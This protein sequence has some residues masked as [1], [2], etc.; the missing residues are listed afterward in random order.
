MN[1][2]S[3][4]FRFPAVQLACELALFV[5]LIGASALVAAFI[6]EATDG[7]DTTLIVIAEVGTVLAAAG[8]LY[9][10]WRW[11]ERKPLAELGFARV[12]PLRELALGAGIGVALLSTVIAVM[13]LAGWYHVEYVHFGAWGSV[14]LAVL[15]FAGVAF[16]EE[17]MARGFLLRQCEQL[18]GTWF[19]LALSALVFG[20][21]H[22]TN[23]NATV[24]SVL[25]IAV[26]AGVLLG[27]A[28]LLTRSLWLAIGVHWAWNVCEGPIYGAPVSGEKNLFDPLL[29][30]HIAGPRLWTGGEFGPEGGL[31]TMLVAG[32][33]GCVLLFFATRGGVVAVPWRRR[34]QKSAA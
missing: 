5:V 11:I 23:P 6:V 34:R 8:T 2:V 33:A 17:T 19:A 14:A 27:A 31:T 24:V 13:A 7:S 10:A 26:E 12:H 15:F 32:A 28:Y 22:A 30:A 4:W 25:A 20:A 16:A 21:A 3:K 9:A 29:H 1:L 18:G